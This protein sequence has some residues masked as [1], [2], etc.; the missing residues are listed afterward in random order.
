MPP[1]TTTSDQVHAYR[2]GLRRLQSALVRRQAVPGADPL[3][4]QH[5][6]TLAGVLIA[7]LALG[8]AAVWGLLDRPAD[9]RTAGV[10][11]AEGSGALYVVVHGPDRLVPVPN[12]ASA[13]L[14]LAGLAA[15]GGPAGDPAPVEVAESDLA[16]APRERGVGIVDAPPLPPA[17]T[18]VPPVWSVCDTG[19]PRPGAARPWEQPRV[20]TT[21]LAGALGARP[22]PGT[23]ARPP[24]ARPLRRHLAGARRRALPP[25]PARPGGGRG[26]RPRG[27]AA[28]PGEH[29]PAQHAQPRGRRSSRR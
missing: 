7:V 21:V 5:R 19:S 29:Q 16:T 2:F 27:P 8:V 12:L 20:W 10:V 13:R 24:A 4:A 23:R 15:A 6:A 26:L 28:P 3:R 11:V 17:G 22:A 25:R 1:P 14:V 9:W 18:P